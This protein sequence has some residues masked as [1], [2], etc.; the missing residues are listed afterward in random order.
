MSVF[1]LVHTVFYERASSV[2]CI[3]SPVNGCFYR[4]LGFTLTYAYL[5]C[6]SSA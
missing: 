1:E 6:N 3:K 5:T 4:K 2:V